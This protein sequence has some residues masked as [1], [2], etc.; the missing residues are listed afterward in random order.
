MSM[1]NR[2]VRPSIRP[3]LQSG[4]P[5]GT[6]ARPT[7]NKRL[8]LEWGGRLCPP[9][10]LSLSMHRSGARRLSDQN[11]PQAAPHEL[12]AKVGKDAPSDL[13]DIQVAIIFHHR[14]E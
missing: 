7:E 11:V 6:E 1:T 5:A 12:K 3:E 10:V 9:P 4:W 13:L 14:R 8:V 2:I